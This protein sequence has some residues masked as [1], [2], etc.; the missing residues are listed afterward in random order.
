MP[1]KP[2]ILAS[3]RQKLCVSFH[4]RFFGGLTLLRR[5][6]LLLHP[7]NRTRMPRIRDPPHPCPGV[8]IRKKEET[9][10]DGMDV[11]V[12]LQSLLN[13]GDGTGENITH[14][15]HKDRLCDPFDTMSS[16]INELLSTCPLQSA[17]STP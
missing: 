10:K 6:R 11:Q 9:T 12:A 16:T 15:R 7:V 1:G 8:L 14:L 5:P 4:V 3:T 13:G 2:V 17:T